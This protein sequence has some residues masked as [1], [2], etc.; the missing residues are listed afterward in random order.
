LGQRFRIGQREFAQVGLYGGNARDTHAQ[1]ADPQAGQD[2]VGAISFLLEQCRAGSRACFDLLIDLIQFTLG[3]GDGLLQAF[4][5]GIGNTAVELLVKRIEDPTRS[6][7]VVTLTSK[8][9]VRQS[10]GCQK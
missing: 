5:Y 4:F 1:F 9:F 3:R 7:R 8:L 2:Q 6:T 10:C